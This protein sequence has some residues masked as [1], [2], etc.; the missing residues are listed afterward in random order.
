VSTPP[1][2]HIPVLP[3]EVLSALVPAPGQ[4]L[5]DC[6]AGLGGHARLISSHIAPG[7]RV[8]LNDADP[9]NL[10]RAT[11]S[12]REHVASFAAP[13]PLAPGQVLIESISIERISGNFAFLPRVL[14]SRGFSG[15]LLL[16]D[17]GFSSNQM[18]DAERG[19]S[20]MRD[21]PLDMRL[22]PTLRSTAADLVNGFPERELARV[23]QEYGDERGAPKIARK[24]VQARQRGPISTTGQLAELVRSCLPPSH[25]GIDP[26]TR[27][28]QALRIAVNDE[29]GSLESLARDIVL[30]AEDLS[31]A[32][33]KRAASEGSHSPGWLSPGA[34]VAFI[35]FHSIE[36]RIVK[37]MVAKVVELGGQ[38]VLGGPVGPSESEQEANPRSR[39]AK[40]RCVRLPKA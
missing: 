27:T 15:D 29:L 35:S 6:T 7:G 2:S 36:D 4:T 40:L 34:R 26:A 3:A 10:A 1:G 30:M 31:P 24:L 37:N 5:I 20:F 17:L 14:Q 11:Q 16:A 12:L 25:T 33:R 9:A 28:F 13:A 23:L 38:D 19:F 39:S 21:G 32:G 22:D 8:I 18:E